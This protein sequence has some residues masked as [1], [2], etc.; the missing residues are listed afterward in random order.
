MKKV[1]MFLAVAIVAAACSNVDPKVSESAK[2]SKEVIDQLHELEVSPDSTK[3]Y[4][5][6]SDGGETEYFAQKR[7]DGRY[8]VVREYNVDYA[9]DCLATFVLGVVISIWLCVIIY[10]VRN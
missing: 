6:V 3:R 4:Y 9:E 2:F 5:L 10:Q 7:A 8:E 1:I